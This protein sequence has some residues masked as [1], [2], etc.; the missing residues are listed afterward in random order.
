MSDQEVVRL[1]IE[2]TQCTHCFDE[3]PSLK[4]ATVRLPQPTV[5]PP[6]YWSAKPR[7]L[8]IG[9][10]P[11]ADA[12]RKDSGNRRMNDILMR[13]RCGEERAWSE[14]TEHNL[15]DFSKWGRGLFKR[16]LDALGCEI[17]SVALGNAGLCALKSDDDVTSAMTRGCFARHGP[18]WIRALNPDFVIL[19]GAHA[20]ACRTLVEDSIPRANVLETFHYAVQGS[21]RKQLEMDVEAARRTIS[22]EESRSVRRPSG[23]THYTVPAAEDFDCEP[24]RNP[25]RTIELL[26]ELVTLG[27]QDSAFHSIHHYGETERISDHLRYCEGLVAGQGRFTTGNNPRVQRRLEIVRDAFVGGNF[28]RGNPAVFDGLAR[29]AAADVPVKQSGRDARIASTR[30]GKPS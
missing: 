12:N 18:R 15:D 5:V 16:Y 30:G 8:V 11:G 6:G 29:A 22:G 28:S 7:V 17:S 9:Q 13:V 10:N 20:R 21:H 2:T 14:Y 19:M 4:H 26:R 25:A 3:D 27:M 24:Y 1:G 23:E